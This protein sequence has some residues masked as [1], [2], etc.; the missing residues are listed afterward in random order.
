M[1]ADLQI[2]YFPSLA[3]FRIKIQSKRVAITINKMVKIYTAHPERDNRFYYTHSSC[4]KL[5]P[6]L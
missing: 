3:K 1:F 2:V 6:N 4:E 5:S